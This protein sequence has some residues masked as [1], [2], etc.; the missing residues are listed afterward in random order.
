MDWTDNSDQTDLTQNLYGQALWMDWTDLMLTPVLTGL[1]GG[2]GS[3]DIRV[4]LDDVRSA[5]Q[6][7][8]QMVETYQ[9]VVVRFR[10]AVDKVRN[11][12]LP[13]LTETLNLYQACPDHRNR[14]AVSKHFQDVQQAGSAVH[15]SSSAV[16]Q[17]N[18]MVMTA[19]RAILTSVQAIDQAQNLTVPAVEYQTIDQM[20]ETINQNIQSA[21]CQANRVLDTAVQA[22]QDNAT[23]Q[24]EIIQVLKQ[25]EHLTR[26]IQAPEQT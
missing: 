23:A 5:V 11:Q 19:G 6:V 4:L 10:Q 16:Q 13:G 2:G 17:A 18:R 15:Q 22:F 14:Q 3:A 9:Q 20:V 26:H 24:P 21:V 12:A 8:Q 7:Y 25:A 1:P